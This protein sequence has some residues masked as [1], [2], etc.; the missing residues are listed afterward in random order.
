MTNVVKRDPGLACASGG[1]A[2]RQVPNGKISTSS[3]CCCAT[4]HTKFSR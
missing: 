1:P 3:N 2:T 4:R